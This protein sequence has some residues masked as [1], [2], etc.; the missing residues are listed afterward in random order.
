MAL[1]EYTFD[2]KVD[3]VQKAIDR[4]RAFDPITK[5]MR[6][7]EGGF[8]CD[9]YRHSYR[10]KDGER[11]TAHNTPYKPLRETVLAHLNYV[12]T[13]AAFASEDFLRHMERGQED[14]SDTDRKSISKLKQR[15]Q[16]LRVLTRRVFEQNASGT[17]SDE[18]FAELYNGYQNE[19]KTIAGQVATLEAKLARQQE[20]Q[21]NAE[22]FLALVQSYRHIDELS[23]EIL[24]DLVEKIV[25]HEGTGI[26]ASRH[27]VI[28]IHWRFV[29]ELAEGEVS[30]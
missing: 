7:G 9:G 30:L 8:N 4:I 15:D 24:L 26:R 28:K 11:C 3:K 22:R 20:K 5:E 18:T 2:G 21:N 29:G 1:I 16:Q 10:S 6:G 25:I 17:I 23:R 19:Q 13:S 12:L 27:Q 14:T